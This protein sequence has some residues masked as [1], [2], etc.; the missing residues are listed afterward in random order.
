[1]QT[2]YRDEFGK[3][4]ISGPIG[5]PGPSGVRGPSGIR[6]S[7][8]PRGD[9]GPSGPSGASGPSG[10][11]GISGPT[12]IRSFVSP[13]GF[14]GPSGNIPQKIV[15]VAGPSG[16]SGGNLLVS[17]N[18]GA[19]WTTVDASPYFTLI[20]CVA[21][22]TYTTSTSGEQRT[23]YIIGGIGFDSNIF[24]ATDLT[25]ATPGS[26]VAPTLTGSLSGTLLTD[27]FNYECSKVVWS[28]YHNQFIAVGILEE[29]T[30][31]DIGRR[32][33]VSAWSSN[34]DAWITSESTNFL[35]RKGNLAFYVYGDAR[36]IPSDLKCN[37]AQTIITVNQLLL[38]INSLTYTPSPSGISDKLITIQY[39]G[40]SGPSGPSGPLEFNTEIRT[41]DIFTLNNL[42]S[43]G[44]TPSSDS[45][46]FLNILMKTPLTAVAPTTTNTITINMSAFN[47]VYTSP[48]ENLIN[49]GEASFPE[50]NWYSISKDGG[51]AWAGGEQITADIS[52]IPG[53]I[54]PFWVGGTPYIAGDIVFYQSSFNTISRPATIG[55]NL[56]K[57]YPCQYWT[58]RVNLDADADPPPGSAGLLPAWYP[59]VWHPEYVYRSADFG[60]QGGF[61]W[62][63]GKRYVIPTYSHGI[64]PDNIIAEN[65]FLT[66]AWLLSSSRDPRQI[67]SLV[68]LSSVVPYYRNWC[69]FFTNENYSNGKVGNR[70]LTTNSADGN[71]ER[72]GSLFLYATIT[73]VRPGTS[74]G[75]GT[76]V[77]FIF[78]YTVNGRSD[79]D[80]FADS[81][82]VCFSSTIAMVGAAKDAY[83]KFSSSV[84]VVEVEMTLSNPGTSAALR[85]EVLGANYIAPGEIPVGY[86]SS[87][88]AAFDG[89]NWCIASPTL[90]PPSV[91]P[92]GPE[93]LLVTAPTIMD[94]MSALVPVSEVINM[95]EFLPRVLWQNIVW[96]GNV[97]LAYGQD[98][99]D[100]NC[101]CVTSPDGIT[102]SSLTSFPTVSAI[103]DIT[104]TPNTV[105]LTP[106]S[107]EYSRFFLSSNTI[108]SGSMTL[109]DYVHVKN[110]SAQPIE[111]FGS[112]GINSAELQLTSSDLLTSAGTTA[113]V[114]YRANN[115]GN[116][117]LYV[118]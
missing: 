20:N 63:N 62:Y 86:T 112:P 57:T 42:V 12:F 13:S 96:T 1:M 24:Y 3:P 106:N 88:A 25:I 4:G 16:V 52:S 102:W 15:M 38:S 94:G 67:T 18:L 48:N 2:A 111:I 104:F 114:S 84:G 70:V 109:N 45:R 75:P 79:I 108:F 56:P 76:V 68:T 95:Q 30:G 55:V 71:N 51:R 118:E 19:T 85:N 77:T 11:S 93:L 23:V 54:V 59:A 116:R 82:T 28:A 58:A 97:F 46:P 83:I 65:R 34:G 14:S 47:N 60:G 26:W 22:K 115:I 50:S 31:V 40:P 91:G 53:G 113:V 107:S 103:S 8:G 101:Y 74:R 35:V 37:G 78:N 36:G 49:N 87:T 44:H 5:A 27:L 117:Y 9:S 61:V 33:L 90:S 21:S 41:G 105:R 99:D 89:R 7:S 66:G 98:I 39:L 17:D 92:S 100:G 32:R 110:I 81:L 69:T 10:P 72:G 43:V 29:T 6:G 64:R 80:L 73:S